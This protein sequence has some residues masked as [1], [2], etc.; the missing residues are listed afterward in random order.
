ME[1][2]CEVDVDVDGF[3]EPLVDEKRVARKHHKCSECGTTIQPG[4]TYEYYKGVCEGDFFTN[5]T[6]LDC[7]SIR[8]VFFT[9]GYYFG[10]ILEAFNE[11][12]QE[13]QGQIDED[14][15]SRLTPKSQRMVCM[16]IDEIWREYWWNTP[17]QPAVRFE[18][19]QKELKPWNRPGWMHYRGKEMAAMDQAVGWEYNVCGQ[20]PGLYPGPLHRPC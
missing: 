3:S 6:C 7:L 15:I 12:V 14:C 18:M 8:E 20:G 1:C 16:D 5:K 17:T 9:G 19:M 2:A 10:Q 4:D 11:F 13:T